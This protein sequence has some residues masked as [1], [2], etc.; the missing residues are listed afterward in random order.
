MLKTIMRDE[1]VRDYVLPSKI[2]LK[3]GN[4]QNDECLLSEKTLQITARE[5]NCLTVQGFGYIILD[6]GKEICGGVRILTF[7]GGG[8]VRLRFGESVSE[9]CAEIKSEINNATATNDHAARDFVVELISM[10]DQRYGETGFRFLRIDFLDEAK[11]TISSI[12]GVFEHLSL[13]QRGFFRCS[14]SLLNKIYDTAAY[15]VSL[16]MQGMLWDGIKR[17]RLVW[18][19]DMHPETLAVHCLYGEHECVL[20]SLAFEKNRA[21]LPRFM[22]NKASYSLWW[23]CLVAD[24]Y[25]Q[26]GTPDFLNENIEYLRNL[27]SV[28]NSMLGEDGCL[29]FPDERNDFFLDWPTFG[30]P[31]RK[32]G[33]QALCR[34]ALE[35][36]YPFLD[37]HTAQKAKDII[38]R[39]NS[40]LSAGNFKQ[41]V[42]LQALSHQIP[43][44]QAAPV[45][46]N[47]GARGVS[48][49]M[50]YYILSALTEGGQGEKAVS[51][52]K[53]YYG[54]MLSRGATTFWEDFNIDWLQESNS[55]DRLPLEG[56][57]DIHG[58]FGAYC[59]KGF[60][61]SLCHGW[62]SGPVP[63]LTKY[64]LGVQPLK[65][66]CRQ[67]ALSPKLSCLDYIEGVYPTP[68]GDVEIYHKKQK[69]HMKTYI[70][71]PKEVEII[72]KGES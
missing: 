39:L 43:F 29:N 27:I 57:K 9:T 22:N 48:T 7:Q 14:D 3:E 62:A 67:I 21:I 11:I 20:R 52:L 41:I 18:V 23:I 8:R 26:N 72:C 5:E 4:F 28:I 69:D 33:I 47:G 54:G 30:K 12:V 44:E 55:I 38:C 13:K 42:A 60:R 17:D 63:Y 32:A 46:A 36:V 70:K 2:V 50:S 59:Y 68:Y 61:H 24:E 16:C 10:S 66:G 40:S 58:D 34:Y 25:L 65:A 51:I 19:G 6:F 53:D 37:S 15:T 56:E 31:E 49:F 1:R 64:V 45:L 35:K 71:A